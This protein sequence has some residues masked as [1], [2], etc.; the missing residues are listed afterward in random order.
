MFFFGNPE[1]TAKLYWE[2]AGRVAGPAVPGAPLDEISEQ[3]LR[4]VLTYQ[5]IAIMSAWDDGAADEVVDLL[6]EEYDRTFAHLASVS[7][8]FRDAVEKGRHLVL[9]GFTRENLDKYRKLAGL[10]AI[11]VKTIK[12]SEGGVSTEISVKHSAN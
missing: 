6:F 3:D 2:E 10:E 11:T 1:D 5:R 8:S 7:E 9:G 12:K 4:N